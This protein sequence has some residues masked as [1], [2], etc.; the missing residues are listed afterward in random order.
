M[1]IGVKTCMPKKHRYVQLSAGTINLAPP[2]S[3]WVSQHGIDLVK[4]LS[5]RRQP[6]PGGAI[7]RQFALVRGLHGETEHDSALAAWTNCCAQFV[8]AAD[9]EVVAYQQEKRV[10]GEGG[11]A[12]DAW[13]IPAGR[14]LTNCKAAGV[15]AGGGA[16]RSWV[17]R[18]MT[19]HT[20]SV[21]ALS[22]SS[23][24]RSARFLLAVAVHQGLQRQRGWSCR[25]R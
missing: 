5:S 23:T 3:A 13:R 7:E 21:P 17:A 4:A 20:S 24:M 2:P 12:L 8:S 10:A 14:L 6:S 1:T 18:Q 11:G 22:T 19:T 25:R 9:V 16:V 15:S